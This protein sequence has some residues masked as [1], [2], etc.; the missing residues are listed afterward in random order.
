MTELKNLKVPIQ[1]HEALSKK[2]KSL[3]MKMFVLADA[4]LLV[5]LKMKDSE[6]Q[7]A[8]VNAQLTQQKESTT[9][10]FPPPTP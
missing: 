3:G 2:A 5:G 7:K 1:T 10:E 8:V 9:E 4:L 6:L